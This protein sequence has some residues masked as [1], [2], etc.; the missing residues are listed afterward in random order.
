VLF[1]NDA[2][3][4]GAPGH[5][6]HVMECLHAS[7][8]RTGDIIVA[9][10]MQAIYE[11]MCDQLR[12][13]PLPWSGPNGIGKHLR[14][15]CGGQKTHRDVFVGQRTRRRERVY[16]LPAWPAQAASGLTALAPSRARRVA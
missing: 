7:G 12:W 11:S 5:A 6:R 2:D 9:R 8:F 10:K 4:R 1:G 13:K 3:R 16:I 15:L 14:L